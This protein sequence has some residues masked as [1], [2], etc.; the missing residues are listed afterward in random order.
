MQYFYLALFFLYVF[1]A[2]VVLWIAMA[3]T[4]PAML[5]GMGTACYAML[6][7]LLGFG[8]RQPSTATPDAVVTGRIRLLT[9]SGN[10][11]SPPDWA[12]PTYLVSQVFRDAQ[13]SWSSGLTQ[14]RRWWLASGNFGE[15]FS[16]P[17]LRWIAL[18]APRWALIW[19]SLGA[20]FGAALA[21]VV[22]GSV[23]AAIAIGGAVLI[24]V[25]RGY[26]K[27]VRWFRKA[28]ASC[29]TCY[30]VMVVP[31]YR[32]DG[33][34]RLHRDIRPG[35]LGALRRRCGCGRGLPTTVLRA[36]HRLTARCQ[37]CEG[38][39]R[40]G[41]AAMTDIRIPVFGPMSAGKTR[42]VHAGLVGLRDELV[43]QGGELDFVDF[44]SR[45]TFERAVEIVGSRADTAKTPAGQL[46][47]AITARASLKRS[48]CLVHLF[49]AA[50]EFFTDRE[51]NSQLEFLDHAGGLVLVVD[52]FSIRWVQDQLGG[53]GDPR[54]TE[55]HPAAE[56][57]ERGYRVTVE[58]L[59]QYGV[60]TA[61]RS[62]A[63]TVVKADL[64]E[65]CDEASDLLRGNV[66]DWLLR[67]GL[68][69][70]VLAAERDFAEARYFVV[71]SMSE[72]RAGS[73]F[74]PAAPLLWMIRRG[75]R[76]FSGDGRNLQEVA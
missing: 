66:R 21:A 42:L 37:R 26:D 3:L 34:G 8:G 22:L 14:I 74:S 70:L 63:V 60:A 11:P 13:A 30:H 39:L 16:R 73:E 49:D 7:V 56:D 25:L 29:P 5:F 18:I 76:S 69:N 15:R 28:D 33:C 27:V 53:A 43:A 58:R 52:P 54:V 67:A 35:L 61:R 24:G 17:A 44:D 55:A 6:A 59:R 75:A 71:S 38:G 32:C 46:P 4:G 64:L 50:G 36:A 2:A 23:L 1:V 47:H 48:R 12:W 45:E 41:A 68:D 72:S 65:G 20:V 9:W 51:D 19:V 31:A 10:N 62:V 57:P 40:E